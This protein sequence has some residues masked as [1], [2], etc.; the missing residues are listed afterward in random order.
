M[1]CK[2]GI[3]DNREKTTKVVVGVNANTPAIHHLRKQKK[4][5]FFSSSESFF[6]FYFPS[7]YYKISQDVNSTKYRY[8]R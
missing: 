5:V 2:S 4:K 8:V 6:L 3:G 1:K 7:F